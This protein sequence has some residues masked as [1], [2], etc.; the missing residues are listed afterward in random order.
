MSLKWFLEARVHDVKTIHTIPF[1]LHSY[2]IFTERSEVGLDE[3]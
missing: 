3:T 1:L 2:I